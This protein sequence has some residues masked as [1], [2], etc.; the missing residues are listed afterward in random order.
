MVTEREPAKAPYSPQKANKLAP[1]NPQQPQF[2]KQSPL[3]P[4]TNLENVF[5]KP[6]PNH[7][8]PEH[9]TLP[10]ISS[11]LGG[12][13]VVKIP[14]PQV[15]PLAPLQGFSRPTF[16]SHDPGFRPIN[17]YAKPHNLVDLTRSDDVF[18]SDRVLL[19]DRFGASDPYAYI[20]NAKAQ[21][22]FKALLEGA[23][24]EDDDK[25]R[26]RARKNKL[27]VEANKLADEVKGLSVEGGSEKE[28][29]VGDDDDEEEDGTIEGLNVKLLPHQVDGVSWMKD[30]EI[31]VRKKNGVSP[32]GG[33]LADD[34]GAFEK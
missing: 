25:P 33:I 30:K 4:S 24:D 8:R 1:L 26:T 10:P 6:R 32:K 22:N 18:D 16:S 9:H 34:V 12:D 2:G 29:E 3:R 20:D 31:G 5:N 15:A 14:R 23:F 27:A 17:S 7:P 13:S 28:A 11:I 19:D 21:E